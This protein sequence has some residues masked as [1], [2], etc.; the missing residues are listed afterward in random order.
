PRTSPSALSI[1][2]PVVFPS[3]YFSRS[4]DRLDRAC[5][6]AAACLIH[7]STALTPFHRRLFLPVSNPPPVAHIANRMNRGRHRPPCVSTHGRQERHEGRVLR[8]N[9]SS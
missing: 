1:P 9:Q 7:H 3:R 4:L 8:K 6:T 2:A 5:K